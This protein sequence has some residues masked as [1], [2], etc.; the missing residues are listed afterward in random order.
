MLS[1]KTSACLFSCSRSLH[2][3][4]G[5]GLNIGKALVNGTRANLLSLKTTKGMGEIFH[6]QTKGYMFVCESF[7][8]YKYIR[9]CRL[10]TSG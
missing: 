10:L 8:S 2:F 6:G 7:H 1:M 5:E 3:S 4:F 9:C